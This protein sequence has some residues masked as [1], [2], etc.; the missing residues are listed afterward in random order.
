MARANDRAVWV[1]LLTWLLVAIPVVC[2]SSAT[3][4]D[5][6]SFLTVAVG[7][8]AYAR[9]RKFREALAGDPVLTTTLVYVS[10]LILSIVAAPRYNVVYGVL[11]LLFP[12]VLPVAVATF[13]LR[14]DLRV[15]VGKAAAL[16]LVV[17]FLASVVEVLGI[18]PVRTPMNDWNA[19][20]LGPGL[21]FYRATG[22]FKHP[23]HFAATT[24]MVGFWFLGAVVYPR[25]AKSS[26]RWPGALGAMAVATA[27]A[28]FTKSVWTGLAIGLPALALVAPR[29]KGRRAVL[30][31]TVASA[32]VLLTLPVIRARFEWFAPDHQKP[33][34]VMWETATKMFLDAPVLGQGHQ[35]FR[36]RVVNYL[37]PDYI[38]KFRA[39]MD[40]HNTYLEVLYGS[41]IVGFLA[42]LAWMGS[43]GWRLWARR[44]EASDEAMRWRSGAWASW[45]FLLVAATFDHF[46]T[47]RQTTPMILLLWASGLAFVP[48]A[49]K[50]TAPSEGKSSLTAVST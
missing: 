34:L 29:G 33:R 6:V 45:V 26:P 47:Q 24:V 4:S 15:A 7:I 11:T 5:V 31:L 2:L 30:G 37:P 41:G 14:P 50:E 36:D 17:S 49:V 28:T 39:A 25:G 42:F 40:P 9:D 12:L 3:A 22:L 46:L 1:T 18:H 48:G 10:V 23:I 16:M 27:F 43:I 19:W 44:S 21:P 35:S 8:G 13:R 20:R 38:A 32:A